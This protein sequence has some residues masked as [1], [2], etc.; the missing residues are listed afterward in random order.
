MARTY[1]PPRPS[2]SPIGDVVLH[3]KQKLDGP[4]ADVCIDAVGLAARGSLL[5][6]SSGAARVE[7]GPPLA[8]G[9]AI[10][11]ARKWRGHI[12]ITRLRAAP[13]PGSPGARHE[14]GPSRRA[15]VPA[16]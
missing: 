12:A 16:T 10:E 1:G 2:T 3:L 14:Q 11:T 5:Q 7:T 4:G 13:Q 9:W 8:L 15:W 6:G